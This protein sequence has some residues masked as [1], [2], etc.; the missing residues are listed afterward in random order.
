MMDRWLAAGTR[1]GWIKGSYNGIATAS[2]QRLAWI[3]ARDG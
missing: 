3:L 2:L 1:C